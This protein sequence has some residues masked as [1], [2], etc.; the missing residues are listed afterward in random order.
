[1]SGTLF[2]MS[3]D[4]RVTEE[5]WEQTGYPKLEV[6]QRLVGGYIE[7]VRVSWQGRKRDAYVDEDGLAKQLPPNF[8]ATRLCG[9]F[10][11]GSIV[12]WVPDKATRK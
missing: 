6:M 3:P 7:R 12:I 1:M 8:N 9:M 4:G 2:V 10:I 5:R 11:V